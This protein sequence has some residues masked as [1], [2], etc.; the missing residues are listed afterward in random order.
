MRK[1]LRKIIIRPVDASEAA[2]ISELAMRSKAHW[3]YSP[4]FVEACRAEL[5]HTP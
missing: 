2:I 4:E 1:V 3:G 5:S